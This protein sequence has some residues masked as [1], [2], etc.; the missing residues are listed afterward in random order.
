MSDNPAVEPANLFYNS[1]EP[2]LSEQPG[3][4]VVDSDEPEEVQNPEESEAEQAEGETEET[5]NAEE[6][7][8]TDAT[9]DEE[10]VYLDLDGSEVDLDDVRK[11]RDGHL[12]QSDYT[13]KTQ[14]LADDRKSFEQEREA[15]F[16]TLKAEQSKAAGMVA[17]LA[18]LVA[19][20]EATDWDDLRISD[21]DEY[22]TR[23][24]RADKRKAKAGE[25]QANLKNPQITAEQVAIEQQALVGKHPEWINDG[26]PTDQYNSDMKLLGDYWASAGFTPD[27]Q[28]NMSTA[29]Q[30]ETSLKA[31]KYDA[32]QSRAEGVKRKTK[33]A[34][35]VT[36]PKQT[37]KKAVKSERMEDVFY[38]A[39]G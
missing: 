2:E 3:D 37:A 25:V 1:D 18:A 13:K 17:E 23:K 16:A 30:I 24:E 6:S 26:K 21:P 22:I 29:R 36:K 9:E 28:S 33:K 31:A 35:L 19:E 34:K 8:D 10:L 20:D 38:G 15:Q 4:P 12:M 27:E 14:T 32:L 39:T 7:G 11:W 5:E